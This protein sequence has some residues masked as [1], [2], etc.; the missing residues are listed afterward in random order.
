MPGQI[1]KNICQFSGT[2]F[3]GSRPTKV[4]T[5]RTPKRGAAL[6]TF[7][8]MVDD[9]DGGAPDRDAADW[10]NSQG[11]EMATPV[12]FHKIAHMAGRMI[13][14]RASRRDGVTPA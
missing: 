9:H 4:L 3:F 14:Q 11:P 8:Q 13:V 12:L 10:D 1:S 5:M 7:L 6:M 2:D